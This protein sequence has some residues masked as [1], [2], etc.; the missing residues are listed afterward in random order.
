MSKKVKLKIDIY[1]ILYSC[2]DFLKKKLESMLLDA[3]SL[4]V[5]LSSI[6]HVPF[7][8]DSDVPSRS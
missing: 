5:V 2:C 3:N 7:F 6:P 4:D 1:I 8:L